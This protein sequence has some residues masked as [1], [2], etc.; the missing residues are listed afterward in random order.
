MNALIA[1]ARNHFY[2]RLFETNTLTLTRAGVASNADTSSRGSKAIAGK[3]IAILR[4]KHNYVVNTVDK[5]SGQ[6]LGRQ[7]ELL[8]M[9][10]LQETF[11]RLQNLRPGQWSILQ[12]GN[13]NRL[14]TSDFEQYEHL[15]YLNAL[16]TENAQL[17]AALGN[18]YMVAP[19]VVIYRSLYEDEEINAGQCIVND[20]I[21]K[22]AAIRKS[23]GGKPLLH[24]SVSAKYTMRSDRAQNSRT[25]ALNLIRNRKG[26]LPHIVVVTAE[27]MP[28]RLASLALGTGDI[29]CVYH[30][31]LYELIEAVNEVGSEDAN[32]ILETLVQGKRLKDI[33]DLPLDLAV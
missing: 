24:A 17:A 8:T 7:F 31:A 10:F 16:T 26:H 23:N 32:E 13:N 18:D 6:T 25:E 2:E 30:F 29:D 14:K 22:M 9:E 11:P 33:S 3:I 12:L 20:D 28:N 5:I 15:A 21:C 27:P 4:D 19:D 1:E